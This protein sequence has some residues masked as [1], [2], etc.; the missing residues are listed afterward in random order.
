M[1]PGLPICP[2]S[3]SRQNFQ[4]WKRKFP[5]L[6]IEFSYVG[7]SRFLGRV[8]RRETA[9]LSIDQRSTAVCFKS[10]PRFPFPVPHILT[11]R[12]LRLLA[13][14]CVSRLS[15]LCGERNSSGQSPHVFLRVLRVSVCYNHPVVLRKKGSATFWRS[16]A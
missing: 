7:N 13:Y 5:T 3:A 1:C 9:V 16:V 12:A 15:V 10:V 6:E 11:R 14:L 2:C 8:W 4:R